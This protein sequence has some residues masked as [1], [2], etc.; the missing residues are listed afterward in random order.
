MSERL[1]SIEETAEF[2]S[3][4]V[5]TLRYWRKNKTGP[6][7]AK[8]GRH[9]RYHPDHVRRWFEDCGGAVT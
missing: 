7:A 6:R 1:W 9:L 5:E 3:V 8:L 4:P 2:L